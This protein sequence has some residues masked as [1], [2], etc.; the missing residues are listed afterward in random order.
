MGERLDPTLITAKSE[1]DKYAFKGVC[2]LFSRIVLVLIDHVAKMTGYALNIAI[3]LQV[4]LGALTT[5]LS[6]VTTGKQVSNSL[7]ILLRQL[8]RC[9]DFYYDDHFRSVSLQEDASFRF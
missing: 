2:I 7:F 5:G 3:G 8:M 4:L 1:R 6:V 9:V